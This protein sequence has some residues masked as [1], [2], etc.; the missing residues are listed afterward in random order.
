MFK[1]KA[2]AQHHWWGHCGCGSG[3]IRILS[4]PESIF[5]DPEQKD[6][7]TNKLFSNLFYVNLSLISFPKWAKLVIFLR[8]KKNSSNLVKMSGSATLAETFMQKV[9]YYY[10]WENINFLHYH[11]LIVTAAAPNTKCFMINR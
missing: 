5:P 1:I 9:H 4:D 7:F 8:P 3:W 2:F 10:Y 6:N 11:L